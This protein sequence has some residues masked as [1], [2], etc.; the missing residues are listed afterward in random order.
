MR[1]RRVLIEFIKDTKDED[2]NPKRAKGDRMRVD[3]RSAKSFVDDKK[4][5]KFVTDKSG[6][7]PAAAPV[8]GAG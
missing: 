2:G 4:V 8:G 1:E 3:A 6:D 7:E 5:A